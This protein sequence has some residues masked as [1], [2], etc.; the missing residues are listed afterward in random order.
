MKKTINKTNTYAK[1]QISGNTKLPV[2]HNYTNIMMRI[3][4]CLEVNHVPHMKE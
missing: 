1:S 3:L 4:E 2:R